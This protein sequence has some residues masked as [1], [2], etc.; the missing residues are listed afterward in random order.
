MKLTILIQFQIWQWHVNAW[1]LV[2]F[3][4]CDTKNDPKN[5]ALNLTLNICAWVHYE[6]SNSILTCHSLQVIHVSRHDLESICNLNVF[7]DL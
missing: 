3:L 6:F 2:V 5:L 7:E 4:C 1:H